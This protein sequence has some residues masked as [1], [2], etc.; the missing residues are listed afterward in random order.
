MKSLFIS[1][2]VRDKELVDALIELFEG[3]IGFKKE[4]IFCSSSEGQ[5]IPNGEDFGPY[6]RKRL[7]Q[8]SVVVA[9]VT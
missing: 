9:I 8:A 3:G 1:H 5:G 2:A 7:Q 4:A 6:M